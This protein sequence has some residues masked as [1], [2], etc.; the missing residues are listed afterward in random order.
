MVIGSPKLKL[1]QEFS[2]IDYIKQTNLKQIFK[3]E[4]FLKDLSRWISFSFLF[5][6]KKLA[7]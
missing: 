2:K 3:V 1:N 5:W 6:L 7:Y 4:K